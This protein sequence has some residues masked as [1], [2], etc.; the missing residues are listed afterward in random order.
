MCFAPSRG[1]KVV[2]FIDL[3]L[4]TCHEYFSAHTMLEQ[5]AARVIAA[6]C[7]SAAVNYMCVRACPSCV[8]L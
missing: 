1:I 5:R 3:S 8:L 7:S 2:F 6:L 4:R